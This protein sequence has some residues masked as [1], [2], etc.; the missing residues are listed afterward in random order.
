MMRKAIVVGVGEYDD[1]D[2]NLDNAVNDAIVIKN[3]LAKCNF[4]VIEVIN[5]NQKELLAAIS[6]FVVE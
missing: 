3:I 6:V 2:L 1:I 4:D 5:P